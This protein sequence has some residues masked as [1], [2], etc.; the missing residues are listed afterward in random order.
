MVSITGQNNAI[1]L[2]NNLHNEEVANADRNHVNV[3]RGFPWIPPKLDYIKSVSQR[4][5]RAQNGINHKLDV[6]GSHQTILRVFRQ[7]ITAVVLAHLASNQEELGISGQRQKERGNVCHVEFRLCR[8]KCSKTRV[9]FAV[10]KLI[11]P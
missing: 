5:D 8:N 4:R 9:S 11:A 10:R 3:S 1:Y 7:T 6:R 2:Q